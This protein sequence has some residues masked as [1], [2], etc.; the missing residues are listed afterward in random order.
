VKR[1]VVSLLAIATLSAC[2]LIPHYQRPSPPVP[3]G[4]PTDAVGPTP[5]VS[6]NVGVRDTDTADQIGWRDFF[7][8][9]TLQHLIEIALENNRNLRI[10]SSWS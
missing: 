6:V 10:A 9:P 8:D 5:T 7:A 4:W 1:L 2:T 3:D